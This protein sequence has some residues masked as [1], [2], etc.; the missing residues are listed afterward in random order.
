MTDSELTKSFFFIFV[1]MLYKSPLTPDIVTD[2][3]HKHTGRT[4]E[5][6]R[7]NDDGINAWQKYL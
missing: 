7:E 6:A 3:N 2:I 4:T 5:I 1:P